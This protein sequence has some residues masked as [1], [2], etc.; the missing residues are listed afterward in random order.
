[1]VAEEVSIAIL[2]Q[3]HLWIDKTDDRVVQRALGKRREEGSGRGKRGK[4]RDGKKREEEG[5]ERREEEG[6]KRGGE[7]K[8]S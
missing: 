1:M 8:T 2:Q 7:G 5:E 3:A 6:L 4:R